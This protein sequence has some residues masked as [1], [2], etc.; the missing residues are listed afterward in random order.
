MLFSMFIERPNYTYEMVSIIREPLSLICSR[1][2]HR[3]FTNWVFFLFK[4]C[5]I[6]FRFYEVGSVIKESCIS[7]SSPSHRGF[8]MN[9]V[10]A[11]FLLEKMAMSSAKEYLIGRNFPSIRICRSRPNRVTSLPISFQNHWL[12]PVCSI[13]CTLSRVLGMHIGTTFLNSFQNTLNVH[14]SL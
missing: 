10:F 6:F 1:S 9:W 8:F 7:I 4:S 13:G 2:H 12:D 3:F 14:T 5:S 11:V